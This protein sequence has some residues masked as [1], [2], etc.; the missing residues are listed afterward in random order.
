MTGAWRGKP[1]QG[2]QDKLNAAQYERHI[3][4]GKKNIVYSTDKQQTSVG[5]RT[6]EDNILQ[7][8][9]RLETTKHHLDKY[10]YTQFT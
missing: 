8:A 2:P 1:H 10:I 6:R 5:I 4:K 9:T 7:N 3:T